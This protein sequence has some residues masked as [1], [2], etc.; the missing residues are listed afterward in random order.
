MLIKY[1]MMTSLESRME[2]THA[3][4]NIVQILVLHYEVMGLHWLQV[5][6]IVSVCADP[7]NS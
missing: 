1:L 2:R 3:K 6:K 5:N 7:G 4:N